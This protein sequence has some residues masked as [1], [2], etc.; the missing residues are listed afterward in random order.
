MKRPLSERELNL[1]S[2]PWDSLKPFQEQAEQHPDGII[3]LSVGSPVDPT[4]E[5][6][7]QALSAHANYP[8]YPPAIGSPELRQALMAWAKNRNLGLSADNP[9]LPT[10]GSKEAVALIPGQLGI[11]P[12]DRVLIPD[13]AYPTYEISALLAG[14]EP[15]SVGPDPSTWPEA[16]LAWINYPANPTGYVASIAQMREIVAWAREHQAVVIADE[17]YATL[18]WEVPEAGP[19]GVPS[20]L[21]PRVTDGDNTGL[22]ILYSVSKE[23]NFAGY[24][25]ALV[26]GDK[27]LMARLTEV[28]KHSGLMVPGPVQAAFAQVL[29]DRSHV[30]V[31]KAR[32]ARRREI[33]REALLAA[34]YEVDP[35]SRAG[36]YL[37]VSK[38]GVTDAWELVAEFA[39]A[40]IL[41]APGAFYGTGSETLRH[42]RIAL[43]TTDERMA[44]VPNRLVA[45][46]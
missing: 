37:W 30:E 29:T 11:E 39:K 6:A 3:N 7:Q 32:Y 18:A 20:L 43:T 25:A 45:Q 27:K 40:G 13:C 26:A 41:V 8:N 12:G 9:P 22:L 24:R 15:I 5:V 14:A 42:V 28:R 10:V 36:L 46:R 34:G 23:A 2:F 17:C 38:A 33:L 31:Q 21:D 16:E 35:E 4:P 1:P 19:E 44:Q